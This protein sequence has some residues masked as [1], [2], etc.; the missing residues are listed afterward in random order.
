MV[1]DWNL[2]WGWSG[3]DW[4]DDVVI[5]SNNNI[6]LIGTTDSFGAGGDDIYIAKFD[7]SGNQKWNTTWGRG[8]NDWSQGAA[9]DSNGNIYIAGRCNRTGLDLGDLILLKFSDSG[10]LVWER[11]MIS[12]YYY[13]QTYPDVFFWELPLC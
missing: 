9:V 6:Y 8:D 13:F 12:H 2:T 1:Q 4:G 10:S 11:E 7:T 3:Y 5:D